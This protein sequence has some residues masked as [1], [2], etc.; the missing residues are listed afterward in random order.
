MGRSE[1]DSTVVYVRMRR[2][3]VVR[4][5]AVVYL[6]DVARLVTE[7]ALQKRLEKLPLH[8]VTAADGNLVLIDMLQVVKAIRE[9]EP[10]LVIE[11][12]GEPH[13]LLEI[14][15]AGEVKPR[16][17]VLVLAWL[18]LF[19]GSGMAMMNFHADVNM[20]AVQLRITE[21]ITGKGSKH[22]WLFQIPYS[23]GVGMGMLLF[24]NRLLRK[25]LNDEPNPLEVE[26]FMYQEN[27]NHYVITEEYRKKHEDRTGRDGG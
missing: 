7:T 21:L 25:R 26:M 12:F 2:R 15:P 16:K 24:F 4:P 6:G 3:A 27:V 9:A 23:I 19:F 22:P 1:E 14:S 11:T 13:V 18:L 20:P 8:K 5:G 10:G 17:V